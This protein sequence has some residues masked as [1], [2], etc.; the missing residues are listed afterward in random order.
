MP[1]AKL[2]ILFEPWNMFDAIIEGWPSPEEI[3]AQLKLN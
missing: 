3:V 1:D 2:L